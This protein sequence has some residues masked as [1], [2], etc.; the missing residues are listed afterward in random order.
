MLEPQ[1]QD[2]KKLSKWKRRSHCGFYFGVSKVHSFNVHIVLDPKIGHILPQ[3]NLVVYD[4]FST[5]YFVSEL[6]ADI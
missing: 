4:S 2:A 1:L 3:Y 5:V 6:D